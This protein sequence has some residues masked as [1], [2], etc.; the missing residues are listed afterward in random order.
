MKP[1]GLRVASRAKG[2]VQRSFWSRAV[3]VVARYFLQRK[4]C[5]WRCHAVAVAE[6]DRMKLSVVEEE[7]QLVL[8]WYFGLW[9]AWTRV[10]TE[11]D[12]RCRAGCCA[13]AGRWKLRQHLQWNIQT[14]TLV[15]LFAGRQSEGH[16]SGGGGCIVNGC[17]NARIYCCYC[18]E[19]RKESWWF[20]WFLK[21]RLPPSIT[22]FAVK[23]WCS[24]VCRP[25]WFH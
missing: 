25:A 23:P 17:F 3:P 20:L 16:W 10:I 5:C 1:G 2:D 6:A 12:G 22:G 19:G 18:W 13:N 11:T 15:F 21:A 8:L 7:L 4:G 24:G 9:G 14:L